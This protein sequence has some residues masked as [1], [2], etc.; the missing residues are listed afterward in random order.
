MIIIIIIIII[1]ILRWGFRA[2]PPTKRVDR[3]CTE[4]AQPG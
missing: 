4:H 1:I 2:V 3:L